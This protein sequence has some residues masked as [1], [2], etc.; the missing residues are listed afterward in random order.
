M[1]HTKLISLALLCAVL[2]PAS[3]GWAASK[4]P[5]VPGKG[6][7][8]A[9]VAHRGYWNCEET[10]FSENSIASLRLAQEYGLWGSEF[11]VHIT[12][13]DVPIV[14]HNKTVA[15]LK[16]WDHTWAELKP[17]LLP[18]G[19]TIPTLDEYLAQGAK[20]KT[21][22]LV[23]ELKIQKDQARE[24]KMVDLS[25]DLLRKHGLMDPKRVIFISFSKF[26]CDKIAREAPGFVNQ[27]LE[28]DIVPAKLA[29]DNINGFDYY[30][31]TLA[32]NLNWI[33]EAHALKMSTNVWT[34]NKEE[35]MRLFID[36]GIDAITTNEPLLLR[37]ILGKKEF[38]KARRYRK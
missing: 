1:K 34:V 5:K 18:N 21:T 28:G 23:F 24:E 37:K 20:C 35:D 31:K 29:E 10:S 8:V 26:M 32:K 30:D 25:L 27:Y 11:D 15:G 4:F 12:S 17:H 13:D 22:V 6:R 2:V 9:I 7:K 38:R 16:I 36:N 19:E 3:E 33:A 14:F